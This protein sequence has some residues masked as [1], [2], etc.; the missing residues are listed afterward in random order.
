MYQDGFLRYIRI[1]NSEV[2]RMINF[3]IRDHNWNTINQRITDEV[4]NLKADGFLVKYIC[5]AEQ[6]EIRYH[7]VCEIEGH[8][9]SS[10]TFSIQGTAKSRFQRNRIGFT[11]LHPNQACRGR[12][13]L[14][15]HTDGSEEHSSFPE[16]ISPHQPFKD[17]RA[18][19]WKV[20]HHQVNL[21]FSGEVFETEDQRNWTDD[22]YKTYCTPLSLPFPVKIEAGDRIFQKIRLSIP[23]YKSGATSVEYRSHGFS[24]SDAVYHLPKIAISR[25]SEVQNLSEKALDLLNNLG[26]DHYQVDLILKDDNWK[27]ILEDSLEESRRI[28]TTLALSLFF[29]N[30]ESELGDFLEAA[31][32]AKDEI[33]VI[34]VFDYG[35]PFTGNRTLECTMDKLKRVFPES[36]VGAGTNAFF[37]EL[38]RN[39]VDHP[40]LNHLVYSLNPQ[41]H[42]FDNL[43][44]IENLYAQPD[45]VATA[46]SF[47]GGRPV[48]ISPI[49]LK[50]RWN[51]NQTE[52]TEV[53]DS[54]GNA[55]PRQMSLFGAGWLLGSIQ[56]LIGAE[57][58]LISY[59]ETVGAKG[60]IQN[61]QPTGND[62]FITHG[63]ALYP[64]Y[65]VFQFL[66]QRK[67]E[68]FRPVI[69]TDLLSFTGIMIGQ[70]ACVLANVTDH[71]LTIELPDELH[72]CQGYF[73]DDS[74]VWELMTAQLTV[75]DLPVNK[76][77]NIVVLKPF[78]LSFL[79]K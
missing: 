32:L 2:L 44:L 5:T 23:N 54:L 33:A 11:V 66:L 38:N 63:G 37:T 77:K 15:L 78:A 39:R 17:I 71:E 79:N 59:F 40:G 29:T 57:P 19:Q 1:G 30:T 55:D 25:S 46:K 75:I 58:A 52:S 67:Y 26:F 18:M 73:I 51:P 35:D 8:S 53:I 12:D 49:T 22:S 61:Q 27:S 64:M 21:E 31:I 4:F 3:M 42:A 50:M 13:V 60:I 56:N 20:D 68:Q 24:I 9:D 6:S 48:H 10:I 16:L 43:S 62:D 7:W 14:I 28:N 69:A 65:F 36:S 41:V 45:T 47:S 72:D 74:N 70:E 34:N 76:I